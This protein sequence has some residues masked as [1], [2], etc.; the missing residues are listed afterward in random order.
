M[1][2]RTKASA[3]SRREGLV[4]AALLLAS[5]GCATPSSWK[6]KPTYV[7]L[8]VAYGLEHFDLDEAEE[9]S[10]LDLSAHGAFGGEVRVGR[11][12]H[13]LVELELRAQVHDAFEIDASDGT[14]TEV[15]LWATTFDVKLY[16]SLSERW[17]PD[18]SERWFPYL[19]LGLGVMQAELDDTG[20]PLRAFDDAA[21]VGRAGL[22]LEAFVS[23]SLAWFVEGSVLEPFDDLDGL[24]V[25]ALA[26]GVR[27]R[28]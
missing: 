1:E 27:W 28:F 22:G 10:G 14:T 8:G 23:D 3:R 26:T 4:L 20:G 7:G 21:A 2:L 12:V 17:F 5:L 11:R 6:R 15:D 9:D 19:V 13:P 24:T 18:L 16:E 25:I